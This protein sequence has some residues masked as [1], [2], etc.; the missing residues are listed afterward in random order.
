MLHKTRAT[1]GGALPN[2]L[3]QGLLRV[4]NLAYRGNKRAMNIPNPLTPNGATG[5]RPSLA[6]IITA[7]RAGSLSYAQAMFDA[8]GF[9]TRH[10]DPA[11]L[12]VKGR[13][14]KDQ[15][16]RLP[17]AER[18]PLYAEAAAAYR[19]AYRLNAQPYTR[20]NQASLMLLAGD[21]SAAVR[22]AS[23]LLDL[24][25][26]ADTIA[27]TPYYLAA[28][29]A[30]VH[31]ICDDVAAAERALNEAFTHD[32][33]GWADHASTLRQ[34]QLILAALPAESGWLDA[35][36]PPASLVF[37]GHLGVAPQQSA[38]LRTKVDA[39]L[40][41]GN[42]GFGFG[43]LAAGADIVIAEAL[44]TRGAALHVVLPTHVEAFVAQSVA[45]YDPSWHARFDACLA[46]AESVQCVTSVS[47]GYEPLATKLAAD[48]AMGAAVLNACHLESTAAQLLVIDAGAGRFGAGLGTTYLGERWVN[49][50][51]QHCIIMPRTA[52]VIASGLRTD[53]EGR[54]DRRLAAML[55]IGFAGLDQLD[56]AGFAAAVDEVVTPFRDASATLPIQPDLTLSVGN[57]RIAAF[58]DPDKAWDYARALLALPPLALPL[59]LAGHYALAHWLGDPP[60]LVGRGIAELSEIAAASLPNVL[61]VSETLATAL[62]VNKADTVLA[63]HIGE[64]GPLKLYALAP[65]EPKR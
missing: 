31:L 25:S 4:A 12:A 43:A 35:F 33:D 56:E 22:I 39:F 18:P 37:A 6:A 64:A 13:L 63:E 59:R 65:R 54:T 34:F 2:L 23:E 47:G 44:L 16:L 58:A 40:A 42:I 15:A 52:N 1:P 21:R 19:A 11:A 49:A 48:V 50:G 5:A 30:E 17:L 20:I 29:R 36:R 61:T 14:L 3:R 24:L 45:P 41:E 32:P 7:A 9:A 27:E 26:A 62:F 60:A 51:R 10:D 8:G 38:E 55:M 28:T 57:A 46:Q 53:T